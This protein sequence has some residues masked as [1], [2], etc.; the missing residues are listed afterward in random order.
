MGKHLEGRGLCRLVDS[1]SVETVPHFPF[2]GNRGGN[3][4]WQSRGQL[5]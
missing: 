5:S 4:Q 2:P 1:G 3:K